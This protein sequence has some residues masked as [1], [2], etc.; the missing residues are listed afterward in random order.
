MILFSEIQVFND[1]RIAIRNKKRFQNS[2]KK[3]DELLLKQFNIK[4]CHVNLTQSKFSRIH[5][6]CS[7]TSSDERE[8]LSF[9]FNQEDSNTISIKVKRR[10]HIECLPPFKKPR[11]ETQH[12]NVVEIE[13]IEYFI[14]CCIVY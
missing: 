12:D 7:A 2:G 4:P 14:C 6:K 13:G 8:N 9:N 11:L 5:L 10:E 1:N 3:M